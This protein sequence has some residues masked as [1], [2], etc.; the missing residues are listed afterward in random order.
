M[1]PTAVLDDRL[2]RITERSWPTLWARLSIGGV[3][4]LFVLLDFGEFAGL[5]WCGACSV[6]E[7]L[8]WRACR[9]QRSAAPSSATDRLLYLVALAVMNLTWSAVAALFWRVGSAPMVLAGAMVLASQL[10]HALVF[11][12]QSRVAFAV[13]GGI[14]I[15]TL[16]LLTTLS[17]GGPPLERL[18]AGVAVLIFI[19]YALLSARVALARSTPL[20]K[21]SAP[22]LGEVG[23]VLADLLKR[24]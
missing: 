5:A 2:D 16:S 9:P 22:R 13:V 21:V 11:T 14:P 20:Q 18:T 24:D 23:S 7:A 17:L 15:L 10:V 6:S 1:K 3:V 4:G 12:A 8:M 19:G